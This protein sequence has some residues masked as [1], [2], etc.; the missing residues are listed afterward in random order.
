M[1]NS[2][3]VQRT[4]SPCDPLVTICPDG[5]VCYGWQYGTDP[6]KSRD[7]MGRCISS[8]TLFVQALS[9]RL[10][11]NDDG[12]LIVIPDSDE[13]NAAHDCAGASDADRVN[14]TILVIG[15]LLT[16]L[17]GIIAC[18]TRLAFDKHLKSQ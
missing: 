1:A 9:T 13:F 8:T 7:S 5:Q 12:S 11:E 14:V 2:T 6:A 4:D 17:T 18:G 16:L 3:E 10:L 15:I